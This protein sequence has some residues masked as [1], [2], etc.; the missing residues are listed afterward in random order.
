MNIIFGENINTLPDN[1]TILEL[2]SFRLAGEVAVST[3]YCVIENIPLHEFTTLDDYRKI[4]NDLLVAYQNRNWEYCENAIR[5]LTGR[6]GGELDSFYQNL[7][8]RIEQFKKVPPPEGWDG[9][10]IKTNENSI[11][12]M[13][14]QTNY[15]DCQQLDKPN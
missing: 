12:S 6:W 13:P 9:V 3:A 4:H 5:H 8:D 14:I 1:Y 2:D 7:N 15:S 11:N 10:I